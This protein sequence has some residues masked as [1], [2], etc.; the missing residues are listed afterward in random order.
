MGLKL[1]HVSKRG[2]WTW[3]A[4]KGKFQQI[5]VASEEYLAKWSWEPVYSFL[6]NAKPLSEPMLTFCRVYPHVQIL[7]LNYDHISIQGSAWE[8]IIYKTSSILGTRQCF[9]ST[10]FGNVMANA[11][12]FRGL[13]L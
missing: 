13:V 8:N 11:R 6:H 2:P 10:R 12:P 7:Y 3:Y 5:W 1:I 9:A 4:T